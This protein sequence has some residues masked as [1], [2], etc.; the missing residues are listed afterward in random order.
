MSAAP[1]SA[2]MNDSAEFQ[3]SIGYN[4]ILKNRPN[5]S[6]F[7]L[8]KRN[9]LADTLELPFFDDFSGE[10]VWPAQQRW[11]NNAVFVNKDFAINPPSLGIATFDGLDAEGNPYANMEPGLFG[12][13][14]SL[15]S[16]AINL[17][18]L[19]VADNVW[20]SFFYQAQ[21][22]SFEVLDPKDSLILQFKNQIGAWVSVW[23]SPG[24]AQ[25]NFRIAHIQV[26]DPMY[27]HE[28]FQFRWI[29]YAPYIGNLKQW[30]LDYIYLN[31]GRNAGD[32]LFEDQA[33]VQSPPSVFEDYTHVPYFHLLNNPGIN[34]K[35]SRTE[36]VSNLAASGETFSIETEVINDQGGLMGFEKLQGQIL[37]ANSISGYILNP[38]VLSIP[39]NGRDS[40]RII[41]KTTIGDILG[42][43]DFRGNDTARREIELANYY[44][45]DD[46]TAES[47]YGIK[48]SNGFVAL[49]FN[50][51]Q[52][53]T[54]RAISIY[55]TQAETRVNGSIQLCVW[56]D[57]PAPNTV[58]SGEQN[59]IA[60]KVFGPPVY[61]DSINHFYTFLLD[62]PVYVPS[63]FFIG[64]QQANSFLLNVGL[65]RNYLNRGVDTTHPLL[66]YNVRSRWQP[67]TVKGVPMI[68]PHLGKAWE[69]PLSQRPILP[70]I[71][72]R[73]YPNPASKTLHIQANGAYDYSLSDIQGR[74]INSGTSPEHTIDVSE[75]KPGIYLI[76]IRF[77][78]GENAIEK[79]I[80]QP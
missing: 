16:Q 45:Y 31:R 24:I 71:S 53:D 20:L 29:N 14:D 78:N 19:S 7:L 62:T 35:G 55:F 21:G 18:N 74:I 72:Y 43:N 15:I 25:D 17:N 3:Q 11:A 69:I 27:F 47:G 37:N 57:L 56:S 40:A 26:S 32:T 66:F 13:C 36:L 58:A 4:P 80:I 50:A 64:W 22:R 1:I 68:R 33:L 52:G 51:L 48:F 2:Q 8:S 44:A 59:L 23:S 6:G 10:Q 73:V 77:E 5:Y 12:P 41:V 49:G 54:L 30:H 9:I 61:T 75:L 28:G 34:L 79:I 46:G 70:R 60:R 65:D 39:N 67:A 76:T 63:R 42:G 38:N